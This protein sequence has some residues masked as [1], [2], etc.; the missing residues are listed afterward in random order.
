MSARNL[1]CG[2]EVSAEVAQGAVSA[3]SRARMSEKGN[4]EL[5]G[6]RRG[7]SSTSVLNL[8][9]CVFVC[10]KHGLIPEKPENW[11]FEGGDWWGVECGSSLFDTRIVGSV[12]WDVRGGYHELGRVCSVCAC[13]YMARQR[14]VN[15]SYVE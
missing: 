14:P 11:N 7:F 1:S 3:A 8:C 15:P 10:W 4:G 6:G 5:L 9:V 12:K 2:C 13:V